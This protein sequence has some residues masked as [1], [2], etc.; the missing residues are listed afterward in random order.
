[1]TQTTY[2]AALDRL[3]AHIEEHRFSGSTAIIKDALNNKPV[4]LSDLFFTLDK[5][6]REDV[7]TVMSLAQKHGFPRVE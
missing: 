6:R 3:K 1:M 2:N 5:K 4:Q 7:F